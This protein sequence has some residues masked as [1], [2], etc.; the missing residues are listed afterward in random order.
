MPPQCYFT[1]NG[2]FNRGSDSKLPPSSFNNSHKKRSG[3]LSEIHHFLICESTSNSS[4]I[5][6]REAF[7]C[8]PLI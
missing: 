8:Q 3:N 5:G 1:E 6:L 7:M 4:S 2:S